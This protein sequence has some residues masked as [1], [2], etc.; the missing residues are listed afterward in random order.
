[1]FTLALHHLNT[2]L[3][4]LHLRR[5]SP[6]NP[7]TP[8]DWLLASPLQYLTQLLYRHV[9]LPLRGRPFHPP[10]G[11]RPIRVVCLSDTHNLIP[12]YA[13]PDGDVLVHCG[14]LTVG[15]TVAELQKQVDWLRGLGHRW[16]VVVG[17]NH[18]A[19]VDEGVREELGLGVGGEV[20][21]TGVE[22]L[23]DRGVELEFEGG[24]RLNVYGW[25]AVPWCGEGFALQYQRE[26]H[27]WQGR[28]PDETDLLVTHTPPR[29][30]LDLGLGCAGLLDEVW[31]VKPKLHVFGHTHYGYGKEAVYYDECQRAYESLMSRPQRGPFYDMI[32]SAR[33]TDAFNVFWYGVSNILWKWIMLGPGTNNGG[34]MAN[35]SLMYGNSGK[36]RNPVTV[37]DL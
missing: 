29:H 35:V 5:A 10:R 23:C 15:G 27:P 1:M 34:L 16:K 32:P 26:K 11:R 36:L 28:I 25:G 12:G 14:D 7:P 6:W 18:D 2:L 20:D 13:V 37:V 17:G 31:R 22:Y 21:W 9:L 33:W 30:H 4:L 24:R 8:L 19:W 3:Q